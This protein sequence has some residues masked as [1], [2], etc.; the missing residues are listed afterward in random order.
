M[1]S[2]SPGP[3]RPGGFRARL[4]YCR[5]GT[6]AAQPA[7]PGRVT[8]PMAPATDSRRRRRRPA[9]AFALL[10]A[11]SI[12][13]AVLAPLAGAGNVKPKR[14]G[15]SGNIP[16]PLCPKNCIV[17]GSVTGFQ[18]KANGQHHV[19]R[20]PS[21]GKIVS[22]AIDLGTPNKTQRKAFG[23]KDFFGTKAY[24]QET[25]ARIAILKA[26]KH[27]TYKLVRESPTVKLDQAFGERHY[28]TLKRPLRIRK[29]QIVALTTPT[30]VPALTTNQFVQGSTWRASRK[31]GKCRGNTIDETRRLAIAARPQTKLGSTR[32]Y[33]CIY[34]D[35]LLYWAYYVPGR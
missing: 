4:G 27:G 20:A 19:T 17:T 3:E 32:Q 21:G 13:A 29:G 2:P 7:H 6:F 31:K 1:G 8:D 5:S 33:G 16:R 30:W 15:M 28:I 11:A 34:T 14:L 26:R 35:T 25:T 18:L 10:C 12:A 9:A 22:W 24:G 23:A